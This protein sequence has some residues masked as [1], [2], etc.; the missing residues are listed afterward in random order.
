[1]RRRDAYDVMR[2]W[3]AVG[4]GERGAAF[5]A[6]FGRDKGMAGMAGTDAFVTAPGV[7]MRPTCW[8]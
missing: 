4:R 6:E 8:A 1:M 5:A 2:A 7:A 3:G